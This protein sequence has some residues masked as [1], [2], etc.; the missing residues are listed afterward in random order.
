VYS[1]AA[2]CFSPSTR[3][4]ESALKDELKDRLAYWEAG[5]LIVFNLVDAI[6]GDGRLAPRV[7]A[8][9]DAFGIAYTGCGTSALFEKLSKVGTKLKLARAGIPTPGLVF[10]WD[11]T[12]S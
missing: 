4:V 5:P 12:P 1:R 7:P 3:G 9:L 11:R 8:R 6:E 10:G 2:L